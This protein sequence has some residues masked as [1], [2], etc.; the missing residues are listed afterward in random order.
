MVR[1]E[2][3]SNETAEAALDKM[4]GLVLREAVRVERSIPTAALGALLG[5][6]TSQKSI[7]VQVV[8]AHYRTKNAH[9][10]KLVKGNVVVGAQILGSPR[11]ALA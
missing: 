11:H 7:N 6:G 10:V 1:N 2:R 4:R 9:E 3:I 8:K 5:I